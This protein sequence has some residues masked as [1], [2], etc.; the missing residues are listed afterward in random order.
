MTFM[1]KS[2][3]QSDFLLQQ[4][5]KKKLRVWLSEQIDECIHTLHKV[6]F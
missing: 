2:L 3:K 1:K 5:P 6:G 4:Y